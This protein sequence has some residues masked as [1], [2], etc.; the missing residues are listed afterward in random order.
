LNKE[1]KKKVKH[2]YFE[3]AKEKGYFVKDSEGKVIT[4]NNLIKT[5]A[6]IDF[7]NPEA[8]AFYEDIILKNIIE[9]A[10]AYGF[11]SDFGEYIPFDA[12]MHDGTPGSTYHN[13]YPQKWS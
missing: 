6:M 10:D 1:D 2:D 7:T 11:M 8:L 13:I 5:Y 9:G 4:E 3:I 12:I